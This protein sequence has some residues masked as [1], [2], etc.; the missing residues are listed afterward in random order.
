M[1][2]SARYLNETVFIWKETG[3][4]RGFPDACHECQSQVGC[5]ALKGKLLLLKDRLK[6]CDENLK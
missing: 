5:V 2:C 3:C 4:N 1:E 6:T